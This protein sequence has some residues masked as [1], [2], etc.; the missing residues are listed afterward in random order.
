M[1][2]TYLA[3]TD[4]AN[5]GDPAGRVTLTFDDI[6]DNCWVEKCWVPMELAYIKPVSGGNIEYSVRG[7]YMGRTIAT[8]SFASTV[9]G[10]I[11]HVETK[12]FETEK[13]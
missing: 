13:S 10:K 1:A 7:S 6:F 11:T 9:N 8:S 4:V 5:L 3:G 12:M 2:L